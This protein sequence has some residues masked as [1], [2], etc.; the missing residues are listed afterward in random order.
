MLSCGLVMRNLDNMV[1]ERSGVC[2]VLG[3]MA[4]GCGSAVSDGSWCIRS[5]VWKES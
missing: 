2:R 3:V 5:S 1:E 4:L